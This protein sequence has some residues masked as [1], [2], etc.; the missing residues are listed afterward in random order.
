MKTFEIASGSV[1][2]RD[3]RIAGRNCQDAQQSFID[4]RN[5]IIAVV[6]DGCGSGTYSEV[7]ARLGVNIAV[8]ALAECTALGPSVDLD[9][10]HYMI[11]RKLSSL[12]YTMVDGTHNTQGAVINNHFL[13]TLV[14]AVITQDRATFFSI[15]DGT[16]IVN[17]EKLPIGPFPNNTPPYIS[18]S[19]TKTSLSQDLLKFKVHKVLPRD[20]LYNFLIGTDGCDDLELSEMKPLP[21]KEHEPVGPIGQFWREDRFFKN[22]DM[23]RRRLT[24]INGGTVSGLK[25]YLKDDTTVIVGRRQYV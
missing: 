15:G 11:L 8:N 10:A 13:F 3:H 4:D 16:I 9:L 21:S 14:G 24:L 2:G 20:D 1:L 18:Y 7:G 23:V 12:V 6:A 19:L 17:G 22:P 25:G 5:N